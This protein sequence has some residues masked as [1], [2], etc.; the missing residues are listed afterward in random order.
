MGQNIKIYN[1][2]K[3]ISPEGKVCYTYAEH[4]SKNRAGGFNQLHV[5]PN[6]VH[7]YEDP[8]CC[9]CYMAVLD[10]YMTEY[11]RKQTKRMC[12]TWGPWRNM[13]VRDR[14][15]SVVLQYRI[16]EKVNKAG[17]LLEAPG[18]IWMWGT[19]WFSSTTIGENTPSAMVKDNVWE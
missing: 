4:S 19:D 5:A 3:N 14:F 7:Q 8:E 13:D 10:K 17:V 6:V 18:E 1:C 11:L 12:F 9:E 2:L 16:P 15:G